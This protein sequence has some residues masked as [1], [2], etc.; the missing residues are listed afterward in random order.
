MGFLSVHRRGGTVRAWN[1][2]NVCLWEE[3]RELQTDFL[4]EGGGGLLPV[5]HPLLSL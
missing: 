2:D 5:N 1:V 4:G 3:M